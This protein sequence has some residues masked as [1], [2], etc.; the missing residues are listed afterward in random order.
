MVNFELSTNNLNSK[1]KGI[2]IPGS[3]DEVRH[4]VKYGSTIEVPI[5]GVPNSAV[6]LT[7]LGKSE[8]PKLVLEDGSEIDLLEDGSVN[9]WNHT[10]HF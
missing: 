1:I 3:L 10:L 7:V 8:T 9:K 4:S 2:K 6:V 5:S